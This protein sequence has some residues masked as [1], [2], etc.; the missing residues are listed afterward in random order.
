M[1]VSKDAGN[2]DEA[3][4][5]YG[6][7]SRFGQL[8]HSD[9]TLTTAASDAHERLARV[10][11]EARSKP[12]P[13]EPASV[14][15]SI[16]N[17]AD[18]RTAAA[19][20]AVPLQAHIHERRSRNRASACCT[21][22]VLMASAA[23]GVCLWYGFRV[24]PEPSGA[25]PSAPPP[26][27]APSPPS[28][29][30]SPSPPALPPLDVGRLSCDSEVSGSTVGEPS[31]GGE[32]AGDASFLFC[33]TSPGR[34]TFDSCGSDYDTWLRVWTLEDADEVAECD[35]CGQCE[36]RSVL[37]TTLVVGCYLLVVDG[38][39]T[40]EGAFSVAVGCSGGGKLA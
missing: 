20:P 40:N 5:S 19:V 16:G 34:F 17:V 32:P 1:S 13:V 27:P 12:K 24:P 30:S 22:F 29:P 3:P 35:D 14:A 28:P 2:D 6:E 39:L 25:S 23:C 36:L 38:Y 8:G 26:S 9:I 21:L 4:P 18:A 31:L 33:V 7:A 11:D 37:S 15:V 10:I